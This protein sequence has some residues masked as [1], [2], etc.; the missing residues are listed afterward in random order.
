MREV[1]TLRLTRKLHED[2]SMR[3]NVCVS[4]YVHSFC[5]NLTC[6]MY[7]SSPNLDSKAGII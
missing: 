7:P 4:V 6:G 1:S 5:I 2:A 3:V